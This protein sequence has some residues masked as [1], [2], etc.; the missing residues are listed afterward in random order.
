MSSYLGVQM[1][2]RDRLGAYAEKVKSVTV[3][4]KPAKWE[5]VEES[6]G[7]P[8]IKVFADAAPE[9]DV[10]IEWAGAPINASAAHATAASR[11]GFKQLQQGDMTWWVEVPAVKEEI[12]P[13]YAI[14]LM[15][16]DGNKYETIDLGEYYN[17]NVSDI[18]RNEY[19]SPRSPYTT[20]QIPVQGKM[21]IRDSRK[22]RSIGAFKGLLA[23]MKESAAGCF[24]PD[25]E[26]R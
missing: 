13:E 4:G 14:D 10:E 25:F 17:S 26:S 23:P 19:L 5:K 6:V 1:C 11:Q 16:A 8:S 20:L 9:L 22:I 15:L 24:Y 21:C 7:R 3:N 2:I 18:F 12:K